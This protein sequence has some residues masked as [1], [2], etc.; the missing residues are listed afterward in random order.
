MQTT[1]GYRALEQTAAWLSLPG[2][3]LLPVAGPDRLRFLNAMVTADLRKVDSGAGCYTLLLDARGRAIADAAVYA[4]DGMYLMDTEAGNRETLYAHL[5]RHLIADEVELEDHTFRYACLGV[6]GPSAETTLQDLGIPRPEAA[7][8]AL[9]WDGGL[10]ARTSVTG[11]CGF[12]LFF[13][14][15]RRAAL[16]AALEKA[17]VT[18][19]TDDDARVVRLEHAKPRWGE[20]ITSKYLGPETGLTEAIA[21]S[22][23]CYLG[24]EVVERVRS[25]GLL[26]RVLAPIRVA[27]TAIPAGEK[28]VAG[29]RRVGEVVSAALSPRLGEVVGLAYI[30]T[31]FLGGEHGL[32]CESSHAV[33]NIHAGA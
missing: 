27:A 7:Y 18:P 31:G 10:V 15:E 12:R 16:I 17:G 13:A 29:E 1:T 26:G 3:G 22:K 8:G 11:A 23:G 25:R 32:V 28:V 6:E 2:R 20:E 9:S 24:Q 4:M 19:A 21:K 5:D 14:P 33:V 30:Q